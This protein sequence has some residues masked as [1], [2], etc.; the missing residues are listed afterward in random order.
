M[1]NLTAPHGKLKRIIKRIGWPMAR[2]VGAVAI[3]L[4]AC[5]MVAHV[6]VAHAINDFMGQLGFDAERAQFLEFLLMGLV[7]GLA[8]GFALRWRLAAWLGGLLYYLFGYLIPYLIQALHPVPTADGAP[9]SLNSGA[10]VLNAATLLGLGIISSGA[11]AVLGQA[12]GDV[13]ARPFVILG[14]YTYSRARSRS[15]EAV[16]PPDDLAVPVWRKALPALLLTLVLAMSLVLASGNIGAILTYGANA[17]IYQPV[18]AAPLRLQGFLRTDS[19]QSPA[20]GGIKR[21]FIIYLPGSYDHATTLRYPVIYLLHGTPGMMTNWFAGAHADATANNLFSSGK[22]REAIF[23]SPD[24]NGPIYKTSE[25]ANSLDGRQRMEDAIAFDLVSYVDTHYRTIANT[26]GRTIAGLSDG[27]FGATNIAL[28]HP[29][30][31]GTVL[32][33][34]GFYRAVR[35]PVFGAG[36]ETDSIYRYNSPA[37]Y[38]TTP[39]GLAAAR[40][41]HFIIGVGI[42]DH[43][44]YQTGMAFFKELRL[45]N[46]RVDMITANG[47]HSWAT[48]GQQ[49]AEALPLL[50]P[51]LM[52]DT[53][54]PSQ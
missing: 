48:W 23:V 32:T 4:L 28:H 52:T 43:R 39:E 53:R 27:G 41:I 45:L 37:V 54:P 46:V 30:V 3:S 6:G 2:T 47:G 14:R 1:I 7:G 22:A 10:F 40:L 50:E 42:H 13:F 38:I 36:P 49:F 5:I 9:Q 44:F 51:P 31:F 35:S 34:G 16:H 19:Y 21:Q 18:H 17:N 29:D 33:L 15:R 25:W 26:S 12:V 24:G 11:G 20:I 8:A